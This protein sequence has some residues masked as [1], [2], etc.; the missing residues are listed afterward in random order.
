MVERLTGLDRGVDPLAIPFFAAKAAAFFRGKIAEAKT[1]AELVALKLPYAMALLNDGKSEEALH[2]IEDYER[3]LA[4][5]HMTAK[6][7][8]IPKIMTTKALCY[9]RMGE[10]Q[11]CLLNHNADSCLLPIQGGGIH[12]NP[13]GSRGA[14]AVLNETLDRYPTPFAAWL[15]NIA[16][17]TL[18]E[19]PDKVPPRWLIPP[20]VFASDYD[21]KRFPDVAGPLGLDVDDLSGGVVMEDFDHDG[22]LDLMVSASGLQSQLRFFHSN[23]DGTFVELTDAAGLTGLTGGL[24]LIHG[25]YNNDGFMDVL[26]LRGGWLGKDGRYPN[27]L[28][29][30]NGDNTFTDVTEEAGLLSFHPTQTAAWF[31]YNGDGWLDIFIGNESIPPLRQVNPCELY[32]NN[33]NAT[34]PP[35]VAGFGFLGFWVQQAP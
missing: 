7:E 6:E 21:I 1:P 13:A 25:D 8:N 18:G 31:D 10:Q 27:S 19:Y 29:R 12:K 3:L 17:M 32:R 15:F 14:I 28:L 23:G 24:N 11:N 22:F 33:R 26:V 20:E 2:E 35:F 30:N 5:N 34:R 9:L 4:E 16:Y